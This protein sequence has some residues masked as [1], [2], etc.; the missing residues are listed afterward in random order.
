M[1]RVLLLGAGKIGRM[2]ARLL[3]DSGDYDLCVADVS[4]AALERLQQRLDVDTLTLDAGDPQALRRAIEPR[5][6]V[7]SALSY[8]DNPAVAKAA[9]ETGVSY[10]DLSEDVKTSHLVHSLSQNT[11]DGQIMM[12]QCGLAPGFISMIA[13]HLAAQFDSLDSV[14]MRVG[15]LP[16]YPNNVLKYNLTWSTD[17]LIN[18]Y[19]NPCEAVHNGERRDLLPLE[20]LESFS[21][22]GVTYEAFN[23]SG[24]LG[25]LC[26]SLE[27]RVRELNYKTIR[28]PGHRDLMAFLLQDLRLRERRDDFQEILETA[29]P[30]TFQ[31][32]A[33]TF[34]TVAGQRRGQ[35]VQISDARKVYHQMIG[36]E[37]WSAIQVTTAGSLCAVLDLFFDGQ[38][39][40]TGFVKQEQV[41]FEPFLQNRFGRYFNVDG[42]A[43]AASADGPAPE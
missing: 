40:Q 17:G 2:I 30:I 28:Y 10:F 29:L 11:R 9:L 26:D 8:R 22:D 41:P 18:E 7:V 12:P 42:A 16:K 20:G 15:A 25:T 14:R 34:C 31:D 3:V 13:A 5:E 21:L 32:V 24:G 19:C 35:F 1:R 38:L 43:H 37:M 27:G 39:P 33:I 6:A 4:S 36:G 23:T